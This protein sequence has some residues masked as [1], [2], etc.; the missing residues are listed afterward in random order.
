MP[1]KIAVLGKSLPLKKK[2][3]TMILIKKKNKKYDHK[4]RKRKNYMV[5]TPHFL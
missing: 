5:Q 3:Y 2:I 1:L 4:N